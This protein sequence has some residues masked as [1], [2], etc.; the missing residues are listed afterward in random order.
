MENNRDFKGVWIPREVWLSKD[1][2]MIE[3]AILVEINSL[4]GDDGCYA[5]N[6][7]LADFCNTSLSKVTR[8]ISQLKKLGYVTE[9]SFNGRVRVLKS[10]LVKMT[11][12]PSQND[13]AD[14]SKRLGDKNNINNNTKNIK[15]NKKKDIFSDFNFTEKIKQG[16]TKWLDYKKQKGQT[17][18]EIGL[19]TLLK[20]INKGYLAYGEQA[21]IDSI[22]NCIANNYTG[23]FINAPKTYTSYNK[24]DSKD[25]VMKQEYTEE[26]IKSVFRNITEI[27]LDELDI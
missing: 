7:Y 4:D 18:K 12:L 20:N 17:Y 2:D 23:L 1:I 10:C 11:N 9:K 25:M 14:K 3:K 27:N 16:I 19:N 15:E 21:V 5:T 13:E 22:D 24:K 6:E 8:S 26:E